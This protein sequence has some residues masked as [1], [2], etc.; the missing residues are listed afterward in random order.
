MPRYNNRRRQRTYD[1]EVILISEITDFDD[2]GNP[3]KTRKEKTVLCDLD[4]ISRAE[5]YDAS[6]A[7]MKPEVTFVIHL[8][9]YEGENI[10]EYDNKEYKVIRTYAND[11][12]E[13]ELTCE[14]VVG[15]G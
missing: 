8:F 13:V 3:I 7:G 14:R 12:E 11:Y 15:N 10:V 6:V 1:H 4:S 9:E 2:I 5:F